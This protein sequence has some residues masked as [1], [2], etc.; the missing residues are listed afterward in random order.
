MLNH[1][2]A[3]QLPDPKAVPEFVDPAEWRKY[4]L[5]TR[6]YYA[7]QES[8]GP[9]LPEGQTLNTDETHTA[10]DCNCCGNVGDDCED[11][12]VRYVT[13][14]FLASLACCCVVLPGIM[15]YVGVNYYYCQ[16]IFAP[17]LILCG[18]MSYLSCILFLCHWKENKTFSIKKVENK[19]KYG[20]ILGFFGILV[21]LWAWGFGRIFSVSES[22]LGMLD[23]PMMSDPE[24]KLYLYEFPFWLTLFPFMF[25][26]L[27]LFGFFCYASC[28]CCCD[29]DDD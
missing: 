22:N 25:I 11:L 18:V 21:I 27:F 7:S 23:D 6:A 16:D 9:V 14:G 8:G 1:Q 13:Y 26:F 19:C 29:N 10:T 17:W 3:I 5:E 20:A 24:C 28:I 15:I 2:D 12:S 4:C